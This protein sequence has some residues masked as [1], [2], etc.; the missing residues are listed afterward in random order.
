MEVEIIWLKVGVYI[1]PNTPRGTNKNPNRVP[2]LLTKVL[3]KAASG[4]ARRSG[5]ETNGVE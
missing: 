3:P 5:N 4:L 2:D 1:G